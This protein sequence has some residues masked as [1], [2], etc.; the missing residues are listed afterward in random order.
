LASRPLLSR[1]RGGG[2]GTDQEEQHRV[3]SMEHS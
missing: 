3:A 2:R 1:W